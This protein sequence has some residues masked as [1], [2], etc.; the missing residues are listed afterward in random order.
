MIA[1]PEGRLEWLAALARDR[2]LMVNAGSLDLHDAV[3][4]LQY[5]AEKWGLVEACGQDCIQAI[6]AAPFRLPQVEEAA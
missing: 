5:L 2:M 6:I 1:A 4:G 3:D